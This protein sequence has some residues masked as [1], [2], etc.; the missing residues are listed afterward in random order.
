MKIRG[1]LRGAVAF[2][3]FCTASVGM[4]R[5]AHA[6]FTITDSLEVSPTDWSL[7]F[8]LGP[9]LAYHYTNNPGL[10]RTGSGVTLLTSSGSISVSMWKTF[11]DPRNE[12]PPHPCYVSVYL[13]NVLSAPQPVRLSMFRVED[14]TYIGLTTVN[15]TSSAYTYYELDALGD[16]EQFT[17][18]GIEALGPGVSAA[19]VAVDDIALHL[20]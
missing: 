17:T 19:G 5:S 12:E 20:L 3:V 8:T 16:C 15:V 18:V 7:Y 9:T 1:A 14:N 11:M 10:A 13:R 6:S 2:T 4:S